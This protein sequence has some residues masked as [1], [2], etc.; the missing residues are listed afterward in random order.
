M[1][2]SSVFSLEQ[3]YRKQVTQ[4]WSKIPEVFRYVNQTASITP[5]TGTEYGYLGGGRQDISGPWNAT[6]VVDRI[7]FASDT[8][9][10]SPRGNLTLGVAK[11]GSFSSIS[12]GYIAGGDYGPS[13]PSST[14]NTQRVD[15]SN[16]G[17]Q[18][19][20]KGN[21]TD[22]GYSM[23]GVGDN[24]FGYSVGGN[25]PGVSSKVDRLDYSNDTAA[26]VAKGPLSETRYGNGSTGTNFY[27]YTAGGYTGSNY[28]SKSDR[29]DYSNDT[30]TASPKGP[31]TSAKIFSGCSW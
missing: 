12:Y 24:N 20:P 1:G 28:T 23:S 21:L 10:A 18:A 29:I 2:R 16:D 9:L 26:A 17:A 22:A 11:S 25:R 14:S 7:D 5:T 8:S 30:A 4:T 13:S 15:F 27:G 6:S 31:I 19:S 3:I